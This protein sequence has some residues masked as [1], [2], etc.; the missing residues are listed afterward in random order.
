[1][2][3]IFFSKRRQTLNIN[4]LTFGDFW[5]SDVVG[6]IATEVALPLSS[7]QLNRIVAS[8]AEALRRRAAKLEHQ[9]KLPQVGASEDPSPATIVGPGLTMPHCTLPTTPTGKL[10]GGFLTR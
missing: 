5:P 2:H 3:V 6:G 8:K 1:M 7:G 10:S 9:A 4:V